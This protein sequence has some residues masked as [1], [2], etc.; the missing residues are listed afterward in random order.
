M[1]EL[2][3]IENFYYNEYIKTSIEA[4]PEL[5]MATGAGWHGRRTPLIKNVKH[6]GKIYKMDATKIKL[7]TTTT[8]PI[9]L[10]K[11]HAKESRIHGY[12]VFAKVNIKQF[13]L[14]TFYPADTLN[15][16]PNAQ[17]TKDS[18]K[19]VS[20]LTFPFYS[21][22]CEE[23]KASKIDS[24]SDTSKNEMIEYN[25][26]G[27]DIDDNYTMI[28]D[29][30]FKDASHLGHLI[31][32]AAKH[33]STEKSIKVYKTISKLRENCAFYLCKGGLH[34]AVIALKDI[35]EGVELFINYGIDYWL[36]HNK[37]EILLQT[38][39]ITPSEIAE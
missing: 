12:G 19:V 23:S 22:R 20:Y 34:V 4:I 9:E 29:P 18:L 21:K 30:R 10:D 36:A 11:V 35:K 32:D 6:N 7:L 16:M 37:M 13:D 33:N 17:Q 38:K 25:D 1:T 39:K 28:G 14:I 15:F 8:C 31:N 27:F 5:A 24:L 3:Q 26:Y 2:Q